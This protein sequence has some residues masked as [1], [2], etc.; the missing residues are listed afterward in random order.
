MKFK[1]II[2][3]TFSIIVL[4]S[5]SWA[6]ISNRPERLHNH[7]L[8]QAQELLLN[9]FPYVYTNGLGI[10]AEEWE[11]S[12]RIDEDKK[13][14]EYRRRPFVA[15]NTKKEWYATFIIPLESITA[16]KEEHKGHTFTIQTT[17]SQ[18][19]SY[20]FDLLAAKSSSLVINMRDLDSVRN[21]AE[22]VYNRIKAFC[23]E[24]AKRKD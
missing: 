5:V 18:I 16:I 2:T 3:L 9:N 1:K 15:N 8:D 17:E 21:L 19:L 12:I 13:V 4:H 6:Q 7:T 11:Q 22:R 23:N 10:D 20:N 14:I 24:E